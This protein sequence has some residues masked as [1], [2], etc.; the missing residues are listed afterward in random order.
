VSFIGRSMGTIPGV[1][2]AIIVLVGYVLGVSGVI[3]ATGAITALLFQNYLHV[4]LPWMV[5]S[6]VFTVG[7]F[8]V[9]ATGVRR[10][11]RVA[12]L[13]FLLEMLVL[14]VVAVIVLVVHGDSINWQPF[15]PASSP[16]GFKGIGLA[17]PLGVYMFVGWE[18]SATLAEETSDPRR[19]IPR[20]IF[21]SIALMT[22]TYLFLSFASIVGFGDSTKAIAQADI[23]FVDLATSVGGVLG[24][25][26]VIAGFTSTI[27]A[28]IAATNSQARLLFNAGRERLLPSFLG[29]VTARQTPL[30]SYVVFFVIATAIALGYGWNKPPL[31][32]FTDLVTLGTIL[33]TVVYLLANISLPVY[34]LRHDRAGL[35]IVRH[36]AL[37]ILGALALLYPLYS[38]VQP[39]QQPPYSY[40]PFIALGV[41]VVAAVYAAIRRVTDPDIGDRL[42]S[43]IA[44]H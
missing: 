15:N 22:V 32:T 24:L 3:A 31:T 25:L 12:G 21:T 44:D 37:P 2:S 6:L 10:S 11:T 43:I 7:A 27:S 29:T 36:M 35:N 26:A 1:A 28:L 5:P 34:A 42:G 30:V 18:N 23:P 8:V 38:L 19:S 13:F 41:V 9:M 16:E 4:D 39:G 33:I 17:F 20:A 40:F 14:F